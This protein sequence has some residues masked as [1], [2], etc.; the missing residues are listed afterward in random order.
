MPILDFPYF[1]LFAR[2]N[3]VAMTYDSTLVHIYINTI[4]K[5]KF[6]MY[7]YYEN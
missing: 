1:L 6:P 3:I 5:M 2:K 4:W 7:R